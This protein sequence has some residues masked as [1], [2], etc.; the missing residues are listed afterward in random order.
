[1]ERAPDPGLDPRPGPNADSDHAPQPR[2]G[3][4]LAAVRPQA[5]PRARGRW[6]VHGVGRSEGRGPRA[7][8]APS[9]GAAEGWKGGPGGRVTDAYFCAFLFSP[10]P[11]RRVT[12][13]VSG[14]AESAPVP[15]SVRTLMS[16]SL[17][18]V[19]VFKNCVTGDET[20]SGKGDSPVQSRG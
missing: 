1:M 3:L 6:S 7:G 15:G 4:V 19:N 9:S 10:N 2:P 17:C 12:V 20:D 14:P 16:Y 13:T 18:E 8:A 5:C 11:Q